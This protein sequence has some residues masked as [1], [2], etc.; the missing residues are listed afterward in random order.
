MIFR[1]KMPNIIEWDRHGGRVNWKPRPVDMTSE[2]AHFWILQTDSSRMAVAI[3][4]HCKSSL[5]DEQVKKIF[6]DIIF[7]KLSG[8]KGNTDKDYKLFDRIRT[9][10][11]WRWFNSEQE[12]VAYLEEDAKKHRSN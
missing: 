1:L 7:T 8:I 3:C 12:I 4:K 10:E 5:T 6:S 9:I 2:G 11:V